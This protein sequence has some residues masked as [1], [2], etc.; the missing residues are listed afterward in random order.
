MKRWLLPAAIA[1]AAACAFAPAAQANTDLIIS[2]Y[3][4]GSSNNKA[5]EIWNHTGAAV[6]LTAGGYKLQIYFNGGVTPTGTISLTGVRRT[7]RLRRRQL[8]R[9][10]GADLGRRPDDREPQLQRR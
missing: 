7:R 1:C 10:R 6:D 3:T 4:E 9:G 2:E 5:I 8:G